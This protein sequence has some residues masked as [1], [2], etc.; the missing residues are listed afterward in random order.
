[1][2]TVSVSMANGWTTVFRVTSL[3]NT[4]DILKAMLQTSFPISSVAV[5]DEEG[6][7][8][9]F[10]PSLP[11][12]MIDKNYSPLPLPIQEVERREYLNFIAFD[13]AIPKEEVAS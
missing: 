13:K 10:A 12:R 4:E 8:M 6:R 2:F 7:T 1:M 11:L 9:R 5:Q 3:I